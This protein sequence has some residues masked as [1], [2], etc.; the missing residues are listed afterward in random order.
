MSKKLPYSLSGDNLSIAEISRY[1]EITDSSLKYLYRQIIQNCL[2]PKA[3]RASLEDEILEHWKACYGTYTQL[4]S[5]LKGAFKYRHWLAHGRYWEPKMG[6]SY[7]YFTVLTIA[8][9]IYT[10][11]PLV[12][13]QATA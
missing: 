7:D 13:L 6:Q 12:Q 10:H 4:I 1:Y 3:Q 5:D 11:L 8:Q 2:A 9:N